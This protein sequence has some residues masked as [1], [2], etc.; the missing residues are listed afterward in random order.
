MRIS[1]RVVIAACVT[2][3]S[4]VTAPAFAFEGTATDGQGPSAAVIAA[5]S[6]V[7]VLKA[8]PVAPAGSLTALQYAAEGGHP[9]AQWKLGRMYADG[10]G[11]PRD[12]LRAFEYF[13]RIA[14]QHAEDNPAAP[15]A[16]IVANAFVALGRYYTAG[17]ANS[18]I[19]AD[20]ERAREMYSYAASYFGNAEAQYSLARMYLDGVG[21]PRDVKYGVRWL[22]LAAQKGQHQA[23]A[24]LGQM[25]FNGDHLQRQAARGLMWLTLAQESATADESWIHESYNAAI[26]KAS[27]D[28]RA[29]ALKMLERWVQ[30]RR[31]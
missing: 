30:G 1:R 19:K 28:D 16:T 13:S 2:V 27:E 21:A 9:A 6:G 7:A 25:L 15:Q 22:G 14:N 10:N 11:V 12:D 4:I 24:L 29:M 18:R 5:P 3:T 17:I 8:A 26:R 31:D 23:Q 20:P